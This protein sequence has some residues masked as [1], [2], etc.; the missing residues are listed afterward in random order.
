MNWMDDTMESENETR[1]VVGL[2][3]AV[4]LNTLASEDASES[5]G[6][7][8]AASKILG[9]LQCSVASLVMMLGEKMTSRIGESERLLKD[10][11]E[12]CQTFA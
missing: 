2:R 4:G 9:H 8:F 5:T 3:D 12:R 6:H 10:I 11:I 1:G 7:R